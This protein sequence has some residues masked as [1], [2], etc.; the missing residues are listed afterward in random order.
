M[1]YRPD[2][3]SM[4]E[5]EELDTCKKNFVRLNFK[6][7]EMFFRTFCVNKKAEADYLLRANK[8]S[9]R[10]GIQYWYNGKDNPAVANLLFSYLGKQKVNHLITFSEFIYF[11]HEL[12]LSESHQNLLVFKMLSENRTELKVQILLKQFVSAEPG[13]PLANEI[14]LILD[15]YLSKTLTTMK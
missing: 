10:K 7:L 11:V 4:Q 5:I 12:Q 1:A 8:D 15:S 13:S 6:R 9:F 14:S 3:T 2:A